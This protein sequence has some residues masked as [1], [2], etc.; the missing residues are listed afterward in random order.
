MLSGPDDLQHF[1]EINLC[2]TSS[3]NGWNIGGWAIIEKLNGHQGD[4][5]FLYLGLTITAMV[6][7]AQCWMYVS[8]RGRIF[9][10]LAFLNTLGLSLAWFML[11]L[12]IPL[13]WVDIAGWN[14]RLTLLVLL[15]G[16]SVS[17]AVKGFGFL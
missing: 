11:A 2:F 10:G 8:M 14:V 1:S 16:L 9:L 6:F 3:F 17:N 15:V 7:C 4:Y 5:G 12:F 13:L